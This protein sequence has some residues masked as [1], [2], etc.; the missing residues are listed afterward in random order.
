MNKAAAQIRRIRPADIGEIVAAYRWLFEPPATPPPGWDAAIAEQRLERLCQS[1]RGTVLVAELA[2]KIV[3]FCTVYLDVESVR[4]GQRSW[5]ND[6]A[7]DPHA[8]SRG[9]GSALLAS[10]RTWAREQGAAV[11]QLDSSAARTDAH[12]FY[13]REQP[14][15]EAICFGWALA[16]RTTS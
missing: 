2:G 11:L 14:S 13:R 5:L 7:V 3:G 9:I 12:R 8:R 4:F 1:D 10:A 15:F 16:D 6:M